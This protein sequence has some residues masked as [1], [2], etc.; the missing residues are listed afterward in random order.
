MHVGLPTGL[1][2]PSGNDGLSIGNA[3]Q[4][5]TSLPSTASSVCSTLQELS[6]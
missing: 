5:C 2:L 4:L 1:A 6:C 3:K